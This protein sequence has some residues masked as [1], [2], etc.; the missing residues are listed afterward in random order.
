M[1]IYTI[2]DLHLSISDPRKSMS[3]FGRKWEQYEEKLKK[4]WCAIVEEKDSVILPGDIS[5]SMTLSDSVSDFAFLEALPGQKYIG[6]GNHD[7]WWTTANKINEFWKEHGFSTLHMLYNNAYC[8]ENRIICGTRG[9][10]F[11]EKSASAL[12]GTTNFEKLCNREALRL[13]MSLEEGVRLQKTYKEDLPL[14]V[15]LHF[16]PVWGTESSQNLLDLLLE[17]NVFRCYFG[18]IHGF[19]RSPAVRAYEGISLDLVSSDHLD[20]TPLLVR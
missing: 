16:P 3:V 18:H 10:F 7:F 15:F 17:Y 11:D 20:F 19:Y 12:P 13:R 14:Y 9:W 4:N 1:S 2:A 8:I 6:K 5:W